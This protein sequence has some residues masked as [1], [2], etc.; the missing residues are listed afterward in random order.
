MCSIIEGENDKI[1]KTLIFKGKDSQ[2]F[3]VG[4]DNLEIVTETVE[5]V[6][7]SKGKDETQHSKHAS[8]QCT[9]FH[10]KFQASHGTYQYSNKKS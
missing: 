4:D 2:P 5:E 9:S 8:V 10:F 7:P 1:V 6:L 3:I